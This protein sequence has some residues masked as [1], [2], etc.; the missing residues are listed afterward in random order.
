MGFNHQFNPIQ[1]ELFGA[2]HE[3]GGGGW[4]KAPPPT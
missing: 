4:Q 3:L 2:A 1:D